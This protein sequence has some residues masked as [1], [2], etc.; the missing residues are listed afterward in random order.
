MVAPSWLPL[1]IFLFLAGATLRAPWM[2]YF[3]V[4]VTVVMGAAHLWTRYALERV[5]YRRRFHYSRGFPGETTLVTIEVENR[6]I[7]PLSWLRAEDPWPLAAAPVNE[8]LL[9]PSHLQGSGQLVNVYNLRWF[10]RARRSVQIRFE[11]RGIYPVGPTHLES[12]DLFGVY[13]QRQELPNTAY[14]TVFPR[15]LPLEA[16][17]LNADDPFGDRPARR[18]LFDDPNRPIG[19]R[20]YHPE[21]G[22]RRIHWPA[23]AR[24]GE[25]QTKL[26]QPVTARTLAICLNVATDQRPWMGYIP[27]L[28]E[29]MVSAAATLCYQGIQVGFSV[30]LYANGCL[31]HADQ[32]FR[33]SPGRTHYHLAHLLQA[34]AGVTPYVTH[35]FENFLLR[36]LAEIPFG[37][38]LVL[39]TALFDPPLQDTLLRLRQYR[40][41]IILYKVG[42]A[43][44]VHLPGIR[45]LHLPYG[46]ADHG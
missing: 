13:S 34:L 4:A 21:D 23:S 39:V 27:P 8:Q 46:E 6:K 38:T 44:P 22:F 3:S 16:L 32:P 24:T 31:A 26:Y 29:F 20:P 9:A 7:L 37:A 11:Q 18:P 12:G 28:L 42:G 2:V 15:M 19:V 30:G 41:N 10:D 14:L 5:S 33:I 17:R 35:S 1:L 45:V 40:R 25:L 43:A 36:S